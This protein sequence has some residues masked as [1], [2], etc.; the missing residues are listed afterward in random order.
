MALLE[1]RDFAAATSRRSS[2]LIHGGLRYLEQGNLS[3]VRDTLGERSTRHGRRRCPTTT[4]P[5]GVRAGAP[6]V[7]VSAAG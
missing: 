7:R 6:D 1:Q 4:Q 2:K 5:T 3:L